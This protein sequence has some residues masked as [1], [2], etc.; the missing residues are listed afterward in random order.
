MAALEL[1][2]RLMHDK[3]PTGYHSFPILLQNTEL[4]ENSWAPVV[5][6]CAMQQCG[7]DITPE[8]NMLAGAST[9]LTM[10]LVKMVK[11]T[12]NDRNEAYAADPPAAFSVAAAEL[13]TFI[14]VALSRLTASTVMAKTPRCW[15][16]LGLCKPSSI[17]HFLDPSCS[18]DFLLE[19]RLLLILIRV[20]SQLQR[21]GPAD[22]VCPPMTI[23]VIDGDT[24]GELIMQACTFDVPAVGGAGA[25]I[26]AS[27][28]AM[29]WERYALSNLKGL[30]LPGCSYWHCTNLSGFSERAIIT[31][32]CGGCKRVRYCCKE[33]Q[34]GAWIEGH[35]EVCTSL[36]PCEQHV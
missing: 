11:Q 19:Q 12:F 5:R 6:A 27:W 4:L 16:M 18:A 29:M 31:R 35:K 17:D 23:D 26:Q 14:H 22:L 9:S 8:L 13:A 36:K 30:A 32:L 20:S 10:S 7:K 33:C 3:R 2:V 15:K 25:V 28:L 21:I 24:A 1:C 34:K